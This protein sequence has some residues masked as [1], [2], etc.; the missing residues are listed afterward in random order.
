MWSRHKETI[1]IEI[2]NIKGCV[3]LNCTSSLKWIQ[4]N[5][6]VIHQWGSTREG[7][8]SML[9]IYTN[10]YRANISY[11]IL[12]VDHRVFINVKP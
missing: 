9:S 2:I 6:A 7:Y 3:E 1:F 12:I 5:T 10:I 4:I 11:N 8:F